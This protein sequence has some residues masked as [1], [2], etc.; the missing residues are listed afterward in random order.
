M[1]RFLAVPLIALPLFAVGCRK[2]EV[3]Q[4]PPKPKGPPHVSQPILDKARPNEAGAIMVIMYHRFLADE[5]NNDL[6]RQP[7]SFRKDIE[8]LHA[9]GY[10]PVNASDLVEN[11]MDVPA[12]KTPVVLTFD[13]ALPSQFKVTIKDGKPSIDPNCAVGILETFSKNN[14]D[15]PLRATFFVLPKE[16]RN[17]EPFGQSEY[18][19]DKFD[20]LVTH[21]YEIGNHT[22]THD[23]MRGKS[24]KEVQWELATAKKD[25]EAVSNNKAAMQVFA[26]PYGQ[27]PR[28]DAARKALLSGSSGGTSY[29]HKAVFL[30]AWRPV[31][32]PLTKNDRK[33]TDGGHLSPFDVHGLERV[34]PDARNPNTPGTLEYWLKYFDKNPS[35]RYV[36]DGDLTVA[37]IPASYKP[38]ID[39]ARA[40]AGG[41]VLQFYGAG[42]SGGKGAGGGLS[43]G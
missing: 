15:W 31:L 5:P 40:K 23:S 6:N 2:K 19:A 17:T 12:G 25:I 33:W 27:L 26:L 14:K 16:G 42:G 21:G 39:E 1:R 28:A 29:Q 35:L 34:K 38:M 9:K 24:A 43:V 13:D 37:A 30:A 18:V 4:A 7:A 22:S 32:S 3:A 41:K 20:Y 36:S 8:T 11:N 10:F